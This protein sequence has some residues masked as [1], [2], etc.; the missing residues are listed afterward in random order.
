VSNLWNDK[1][2]WQEVSDRFIQYGVAQ[3][4]IKFLSANHNSKNQIAGIGNDLAALGHLYPGPVSRHEGHSAKPKSGAPIYRSAL[5]WVWITESGIS[6]APKTKLIYYP[7]YPEIRL[8][9]FL[10]SSP[11]A[12]N[13]LLSGE[14]KPGSRGQEPGRILIFGPGADRT[15]FAAIVSAH[16]PAAGHLESFKNDRGTMAQVV[17]GAENRTSKERLFE[18]LRNIHSK[19]WIASYR[20]YPDGSTLPCKGQNC[21]GVTLESELGITGNGKAAPDY[22]D[23]EVKGH[24]VAHLSRHLSSKIT[25]LTPSP[26]GGLV[27]SRGTTWLTQTYG[28]NQKNSRRYD[29]SGI[30]RAGV[31]NSKTKLLF[32]VDGFDAETMKITD[33]GYLFLRDPAAEVDVATWSFQ[34]LLTHWQ[35]KHAKTVFVPCVGNA[36]KHFRYGTRLHVGEGTSFLL[37][38]KAVASGVVVLDPG[39]N[40]QLEDDKWKPHTRYQF[41]TSLAKAPVLYKTFEKIL[42]DLP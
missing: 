14:G 40:T 17:L 27:L 7:Q 16:S 5:P 23:W 38:L 11:D 6:P 30:H 34:K 42:L 28:S 15:V 33:D 22:L 10:S 39:L 13:E 12:P 19:S 36:T 32:G 26:D 24:K 4:Q 8:S 3:I 29:L 1:V 20:L 2:T 31:R 35:T 9:G 41:R 25:L 21:H 37:F 18:E